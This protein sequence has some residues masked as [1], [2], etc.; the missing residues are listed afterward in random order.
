MT[1]M[2]GV[3]FR[4]ERLG[5]NSKPQLYSPSYLFFIFFPLSF[6]D[7]KHHPLPFLSLSFFK[8][9]ILLSSLQSNQAAANNRRSPPKT[10]PSSVTP[11]SS[12]LPSPPPPS[13]RSI[14]P[15]A[16]AL[17]IATTTTTFTRHR[18]CRC[19]R[20]SGVGC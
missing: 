2:I 5:L 20:F 8:F 3:R 18:L 16:V 7:T 13:T 1:R 11:P 14:F 9:L 6:L 10:T 15:F 12:L 17:P 4:G 19:C